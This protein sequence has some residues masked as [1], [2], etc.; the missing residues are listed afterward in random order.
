MYKFQKV[1]VFFS[2]ERISISH[3]P[4]VGRIKCIKNRTTE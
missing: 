3:F 2:K 1:G 4:V